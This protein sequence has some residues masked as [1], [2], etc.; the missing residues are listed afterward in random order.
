M[1]PSM[2]QHTASLVRGAKLSSYPNVGHATF[3]EAPGRFNRELEEFVRNVSRVAL[4]R[5]T[6][7]TRTRGRPGRRPRARLSRQAPS[8]TP[9]AG[10]IDE[11]KPDA[12]SF[13]DRGMNSVVNAMLVR[14]RDTPPRRSLPS[15]A[16]YAGEVL[17]CGQFRSRGAPA[18]LAK[19]EH[20]DTDQIL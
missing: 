5:Q 8:S 4:T 13:A 10:E 2:A 18:R 17:L 16:R 1:L 9:A 12:F 3:W 11:G 14:I 6:R 15:P 7:D 19:D 20:Q